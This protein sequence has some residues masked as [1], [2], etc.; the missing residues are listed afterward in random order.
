MDKQLRGKATTVEHSRRSADSDRELPIVSLF[1]GAGGLDTGFARAGF[2]TILAV[3]GSPSA[4]T[5]FHQNYPAVP[6]IKK[7]LSN[8][9]PDF[10]TERIQELPGAPRPIGVIG[11]PPCQ[12]FS[13]S[14]GHKRIDDPRAELSNKYALMIAAL[15]KA[16]DLD[17]FLFE[18]VVG[19]THRLHR[20]QFS[21]FKNLFDQAGFWIFERE[22]NAHDFGVP[23]VRK[24][25]FI[26]GLNKRKYPRPEY[27][28]PKAVRGGIRTVRQAIGSFPKPTFFSNRSDENSFSFHP[29]HWCMTPR[30]SK[31]QNG[32]LKEGQI[33][34]RPFRVLRWDG[35]SWAVA[36]GHREV[37]VHPSGQRRLSVYEAMRI[38][39]FP[40][41]YELKGNLSDQ[42]RLVSDAVP[43]PLSFSLAT[44]I[45]RTI[46]DSKPISKQRSD[47]SHDVYW[48]S[49]HSAAH[50]E[51]PEYLRQFFLRYSKKLYRKFPWRTKSVSSFQ[52]LMAEVL[53]KQT[54]AEDVASVWPQLVMCYKTPRQLA[55]ADKHKLVEMLREL[56]LQ[57]QRA[58]SLIQIGKVLLEKFHGDVP[59]DMQ[60]LLSIPG[61]GL[62]TAAAVCCF[63][64]G[65][66]VP[67]VDANVL[68]VFDRITGKKHGRDLRR[69][70]DAWALAWAILPKEKCAAHNYAILD[71]AA[72]FCSKS[73]NCDHC[74]LRRKCEYGINSVGK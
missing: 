19:L 47:P 60:S 8:I 36:Y 63:K 45:K 9:N 28:F 30:S 2:K 37:H 72:T 52:L 66:N 17:F 70:E 1:C 50:L 58:S 67:V 59:N 35:P 18:N 10:L 38:Q 22:L 12:A 65:K 43:P 4:C 24:R 56:G 74:P 49:R 16:F 46:F 31:F 40:K 5:T 73:P 27:E 62:Y 14:N 51:P 69:S 29:N 54:K 32:L 33:Q 48:K 7:D 68:R 64:F 21:F 61:V 42:F 6:V 53:L 3:D 39:G 34:G 71:F 11:G 57:N 55:E 15:N 41:T 26:V 20:H 13:M 44:S 25:L 23:Q